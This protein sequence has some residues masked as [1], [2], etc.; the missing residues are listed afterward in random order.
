M[1]I[2]TVGFASVGAM[3][4]KYLYNTPPQKLVI[5]IASI[6]MGPIGNLIVIWIVVLACFTTA[7]ASLDVF[8][9]FVKSYTGFCYNRSLIITTTLSFITSFIS[10]GNL[11]K[12]LSS[13]LIILYPA[14]AIMILMV[15]INKN[16]DQK[17]V[18]ILFWCLVLIFGLIA[19]L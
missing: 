11:F 4:A 12:A 5:K 19:F 8:S 9:R 15:F 7:V 3:F 18:N 13:V 10:F 17:Y 1:F 16:E 6:M 14:F 2:A